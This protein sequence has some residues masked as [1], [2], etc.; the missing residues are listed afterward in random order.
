MEPNTTPTRTPNAEVDDL[1]IDRW[2]PRAF[3]PE[4]I[5][6]ETLLR[7][8]EAARWAPSAMNEQPWR[9]LYADTP[10]TLDLFRPLLVDQNR[11]WADRAPVLVFVLGKRRYDYK[12]RPNKG[13]QFDAGAAWMSLALQA[14][15]LGLFTHG[16]A[17]IHYD[18]AYEALNVP[19]EDYEIIAAVAIGAMGDPEE[20]PADVQAREAPSGRKALAEIAVSGVFD[21]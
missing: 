1:F 20:L 6:R 12:D 7:L 4:P 19:A 13:Y 10:E 8:F 21:G 3:S 2:S 18:D 5:P 11:V 9:F 16:M 14:R 15:M 17:G